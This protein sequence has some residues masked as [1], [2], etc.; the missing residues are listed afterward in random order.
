MA[1]SRFYRDSARY[2]GALRDKGRNDDAFEDE[3]YYTMP[4]LSG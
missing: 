4:A 1:N 2:L 3:Y